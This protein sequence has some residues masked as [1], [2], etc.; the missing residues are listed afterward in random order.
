M[1]DL[2][3]DNGLQLLVVESWYRESALVLG[4]DREINIAQVRESRMQRVWSGIFSGDILI[5]SYKT[6]AWEALEMS[7]R[8]G[9]GS[10]TFLPHMPMHSC[11]GD[12]ILKSFELPSN[13]SP[14]C[15]T[16]S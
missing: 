10:P 14:V 13:H 4:V 15:C 12:D 9:S 16:M 6:P 5:G 1:T 2:V 3:A 7:S 8:H 11:K